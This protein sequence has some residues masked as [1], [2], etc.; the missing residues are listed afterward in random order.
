MNFQRLRNSLVS[1]IAGLVIA[2]LAF[3]LPRQ[4]EPFDN[5]I[6]DAM[7]RATAEPFAGSGVI[8]LID[9]DEQ[10]LAEVGQ[11]PWPRSHLADLVE[12]VNAAVALVSMRFS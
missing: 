8:T 1:L 10:S 3:A 4:V 7:V 6:Y 9:V 12:Q 2:V 11:W 5:L